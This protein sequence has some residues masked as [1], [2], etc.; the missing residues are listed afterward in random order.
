[1]SLSI[2]LNVVSVVVFLM[3]QFVNRGKRYIQVSVFVL[4]FICLFKFVYLCHNLCKNVN[5]LM[6]NVTFMYY[7]VN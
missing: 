6:M 4:K 5:V 3:W 7:I 1:M 2:S